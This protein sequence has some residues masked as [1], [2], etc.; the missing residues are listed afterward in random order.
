MGKSAGGPQG[1][2]A[3]LILSRLSFISI[4]VS[5]PFQAVLANMGGTPGLGGGTQFK[6]ISV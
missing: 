1:K 2:M 4:S 6:S 5:L 3:F